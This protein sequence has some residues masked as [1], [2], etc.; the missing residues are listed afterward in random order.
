M[1]KIT[2]LVKRPAPFW[3]PS[4]RASDGKA[5]CG[6]MLLRPG[7]NTIP[8][9]RWDQTAKHPAIKVYLAEGILAL[10]P[11]AKDRVAHTHAPD[12]LDGLGAL[13]I[14][15]AEAWIDA[16]DDAEQLATWRTQDSRK[17]IHALI[18]ARSEALESGD[19]A[20]EDA[21]D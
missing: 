19:A 12:A 18:D 2:V 17:G 1:E 8:R 16:C 11:S 6:K 10:N 20:D 13:S 3:L 5:G 9:L 7:A 15:K 4:V 21:E 14:A